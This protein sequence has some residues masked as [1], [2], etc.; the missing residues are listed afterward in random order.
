MREPDHVIT[1][2]NNIALGA[3]TCELNSHPL[4]N[5]ITYLRTEI[6]DLHVHLI[7]KF[8]M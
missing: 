7:E 2:E 4:V 8:V 5:S 3:L 1:I 6:L